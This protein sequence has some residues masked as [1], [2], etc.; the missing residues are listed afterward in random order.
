M[1]IVVA[2][3]GGVAVGVAAAV[4]VVDGPAEA[5][6]ALLPVAGTHAA[7]AGVAVVVAVDVGAVAAGSSVPWLE[8]RKWRKFRFCGKFQGSLCSL[9]TKLT[10]QP[11]TQKRVRLRG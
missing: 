6:C 5:D 11:Q 1:L 7:V 9:E 3:A 2:G 10:L 8:K 4:V